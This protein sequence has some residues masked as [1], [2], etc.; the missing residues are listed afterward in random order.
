M[1]ISIREFCE[2]MSEGSQ[3]GGRLGIVWT[4]VLANPDGDDL[5]EL[6]VIGALMDNRI[7]F[8]KDEPCYGHY[9]NF[10]SMSHTELVTS[11]RLAL[12]LSRGPEIFVKTLL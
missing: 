3:A 2:R 6:T 9:H 1:G 12:S 4:S 7:D 8:D 10:D 5:A 11:F